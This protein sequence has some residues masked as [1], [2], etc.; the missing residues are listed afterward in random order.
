MMRNRKLLQASAK[1]HVGL[2]RLRLMQVT[3]ET[4]PA[5]FGR[6]ALLLHDTHFDLGT[7]TFDREWILRSRLRWGLYRPLKGGADRTIRAAEL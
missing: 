5:H 7:F 2:F 3:V 1:Q 4:C 6:L